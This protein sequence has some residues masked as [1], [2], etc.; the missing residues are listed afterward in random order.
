M[1]SPVPEALEDFTRRD[2]QA[3]NVDG[4]IRFAMVGL[5]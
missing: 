1:S 5:G 2:W 3:A 4:V